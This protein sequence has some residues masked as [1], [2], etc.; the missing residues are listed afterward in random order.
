VADL[1][2]LT[3][4]S[5]FNVS[6][7]CW[8]FSMQSIAVRAFFF[9]GFLAVA[10]SAVCNDG[11]LPGHSR[12]G[13]AFNRG[14]RQRAYLMGGT[15]NVH[16]AVS[17]RDPLVQKFVEQGI[18]QLHG[19]WFV[20]AERSFRQAARLDPNCGIAYWGMSVANRELNPV[21][22][23][24]FA[25]EA[26]RH[27]AGL[28]E[29]ERMYIDAL[30]DEKAYRAIMARFPTDLEAATFEIWRLW[31]KREAGD[32]SES[33]VRSADQL[34]AGILRAHPMHP[35]HHAAIHFA[36]SINAVS[37]ALDSAERCGESAPA[38][39]HM[40]HMPVHVYFPLKR[41]PEAAWQLEASI[42]TE[43]ARVMHDRALP[44]HLYAHNN[45][46][47][48]RTLMFLGRVQEA[49]RVAMSMIDLPRSPA[50]STID[51]PKGDSGGTDS[52]QQ[53]RPRESVGTS[54]YY[55]RQALLQI[56]RQYEYWDDLIELCRTA[57]IEPTQS[58]IEQGEIHADLGIACFCKGSIEAGES[59]LASLR[60]VIDGQI[61][62]RTNAQQEIGK[63]PE[64]R[65]A[66]ALAAVNSQFA[67]SI[68]GLNQL[69]GDLEDYRRIARGTY[70]NRRTLVIVLV[71]LVGVEAVLFWFLRR[72]IVVAL[73]TVLTALLAGGWALQCHLALL[74]LPYHADNVDFAF[75]CGK[76]LKAGDFEEAEWSARNFIQERGNQVRPQANLVEVL[77]KAGKRDLALAEFTHLRELAAMADLE[78]PPLARL[79][80]IARDLGFPPDWR[81]PQKVHQTLSSRR[82]LESLGPLLWRPVAAPD[83]KLNDGEGHA[84]A[85]SQF[86][87]KPVILL[88]FLGAGCAHCRTQLEAFRKMAKEFTE[89]GLT[90]VAVSCDDEAG[91]RRCLSNQKREPFPFLMLADPRC[92]SFQAYGAFDD[93][94]QIALHGTFLV[95]GD[96][97][98]RWSDVGFEPFTDAA[99]LLAESKRLLTRPVAP[100]EHGAKVIAAE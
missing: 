94:E 51:L 96:G 98:L 68:S 2:S 41:Y 11:P 70:L 74:N 7:S 66:A 81:L 36:D 9:T 54:A 44:S 28:S 35:I 59:E 60:E 27:K 64:E 58:P 8:A 91:V 85:L 87:C 37:R 14:P 92:T 78:S 95:D 16:F 100:P 82:P 5:C 1:T 24:Q 43:N 4:A 29:R 56:L 38:I 76:L 20:E 30:H 71:C 62:A 48:V 67:A 21:R 17:S 25:A 34:I 84:H 88:F 18:G 23:R 31:H 26:A 63:L 53:Q 6:R 77:Y 69:G 49:R 80:P 42:R 72:R 97:L 61:A 22:S 10:H 89:A 40:W 32:P 39:G 65:R 57:S 46:W 79:A 93:F 73:L 15:G 86:R 47:L 13:E 12:F 3:N 52:S 45:E 33:L 83:W 55:G 19:F 75:I 99:F 90:V 50:A